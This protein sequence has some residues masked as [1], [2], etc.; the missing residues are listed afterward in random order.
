MTP[1][2][3]R[4]ILVLLL[5]LNKSSTNEPAPKDHL[6]RIDQTLDLD[7]TLDSLVRHELVVVAG[8]TVWLTNGGQEF[9]TN[10]LSIPLPVNKSHEQV[11]KVMTD[12][13]QRL[14]DL[15]K[16]IDEEGYYSGLVPLGI[17]A[18]QVQERLEIDL[19]TL[20]AKLRDLEHSKVIYLET[21]NDASRLPPDMRATA[22]EDTIRGTLY[23]VGRW[24][25]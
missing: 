13:D 18:G 7:A 4:D 24:G 1:P 14:V 19:S 2:N 11:D 3:Q 22:I 20:Q 23:Y 15:I 17:L 10:L 16:E 8:E 21:I 5:L 25:K 12:D 9:V 6:Q